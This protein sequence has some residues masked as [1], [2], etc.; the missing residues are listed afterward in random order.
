VRLAALGRTRWLLSTIDLLAETHQLVLIATAPAAPEYGVDDEDFAKVAE[1]LGARFHS[2][3]RGGRDGLRQAIRDA[4]PDVAVSVNWPDLIEADTVALI[5][6]GILN[7]HAGD[8]PRFRGNACPNWAILAGESQV[9]LT[10]HGMNAELDAGP[11]YAQEAMPID[12]TTYIGDVYRWLSTAVPRLLVGAVGDLERA[13]FIPAE[14]PSD[15]AL[16]LRCFPRVPEDGLIDWNASATS[17][18]RLVRASAEP[19][20]GAYT[21]LRRERLTVWRAREEILGYPW[22][23]RAGQVAH[24]DPST[25]EVWILTGANAVALQEVEYDG[26]RGRPVDFIRSTRLRLGLDVEAEVRRLRA[27]VRMLEDELKRVGSAAQPAAA[28]TTLGEQVIS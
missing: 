15:P 26:R 16:S 23:G 9:V 2:M 28:G 13:D 5:P 18:S 4:K 22:L 25:G 6:H 1:R 14:Q 3:S 11:I 20:A 17:I 8:L 10:V 7:A 12:D 24:R 27:R 21:F 19:F